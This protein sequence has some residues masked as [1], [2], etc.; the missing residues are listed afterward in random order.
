MDGLEIRDNTI[1]VVMDSDKKR[2][3]K[4]F[5]EKNLSY[6]KVF[7]VSEFRDKYYFSYDE[8]AI[9]YL[10]CKY[11][12]KYDISLM[13]LSLFY[14]VS[15]GE[16]DSSIEKV[17]GVI[18][19]KCELEEENLLY[20]SPYF[21]KYLKDKDI[22]FCDVLFDG[23]VSSLYH[24]L[25]RKYLVRKGSTLRDVTYDKKIYQFE[26]I[27]DE[28]VFVASSILEA[29]KNGVKPNLIKLCGVE[30]EYLPIVKRIFSW[31][32]I[33]LNVSD[34]YLYGTLMGH[35]FLTHLGS[36]PE[37]VLS[38]LREKYTLSSRNEMEI[39]SLIVDI[40][41][42]YVFVDDYLEVKD[43]LIHDFKNAKLR[44]NVFS[45]GIEV[46]TDLRGIG[47]DMHVFLLG[48]NQGIV[49][50]LEKDD[51]YFNDEIKV[52]L[53]LLSTHVLNQRR[54][55]KWI[56]DIRRVKNLVITSKR[57]SPLGEFYLSSL[58]DELNYLVEEGKNTYLYSDL[59]NRLMLGSKLDVMVRY[60]E[61]DSDVDYLYQGYVDIPYLCYDS[62]F[63]GIN[64]DL[65]KEYLGGK[66]TLSYSALN[67]YYQCGF[68]YYLSN[69]LKLNLYPNTFY[70]VL[71][72]IFHEVLSLYR[73]DDF[74]FSKVY[75]RVVQKYGEV[76]E[77][78]VRDKFFLS[79][80]KGE[81]KFI[82]DTILEQEDACC[83]ENVSTEERIVR[84]YQ[85]LGYDVCFKGF[86]DKM[87]VSRDEDMVAIIDYKTGNPN[88]NLNHTIYGLDLQLSIYLF[89]A[90]IRYP[91]ARMI[92]FYLQ[93][94][95]NNEI[96][97]DHKHTYLALKKDNLKLQGYSN[98]DVSLLSQFDS[99]YCESKVI[100]G[101]RMTS[102][103][104]GT[105]K[106]MSDDEIDALIH[107]A[108][109]KIKEAMEQIIDA[110]FS[111]H[112][113]RIGKD[114]LGCKYCRFRDI[115]FMR[116]EDVLDLE[117]YKDLS[118]LRRENTSED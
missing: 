24:D 88:L 29:I 95:L 18:S 27:D 22:L 42:R 51:G 76:Y 116:E 87:V 35:D 101:M 85:C 55:E 57:R 20:F 77:Y 3:L 106:V 32:S 62:S 30:G 52:S 94:I 113:K 54:K 13:Y 38:Y 33:P 14:D 110:N 105:K 86:V 59:Y 7:T 37:E 61:K 28:V 91:K 17:K 65:L 112:P 47:D 98:S 6:P 81:L 10:S 58:N 84:E 108:E 1:L 66:F 82:I 73:R 53:N 71:G 5:S 25:K 114:N 26:T 107:L 39:Y 40:V 31:F 117:E 96:R 92:G 97:I 118:F 41:N 67:S 16:E 15:G 90:N 48:F 9:Y 4:Y 34:N 21:R 103:G 56:E 44:G 23:E 60:N 104:F 19:L 43:F 49:P 2:I 89:L 36:N 100:K 8:R 11:H 83:L 74:D 93:K 99:T 46:V 102:K 45:S 75:D 68:R 50:K 115:C 69:V 64:R 111:I 70:T 72:N 79:Y 12:F 109:D 78:N 63:K 80:L